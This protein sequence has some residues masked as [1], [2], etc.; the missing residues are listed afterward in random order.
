MLL[1]RALFVSSNN[2]TTLNVTGSSESTAGAIVINDG[3]VP[4]FE[5]DLAS[6]LSQTGSTL[7]GGDD[8]TL[9]VI[10][11]SFLKWYQRQFHAQQEARELHVA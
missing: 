6:T 11:E 3:V 10:G 9:N 5:V 2:R 7:S 4:L 8:T 1:S